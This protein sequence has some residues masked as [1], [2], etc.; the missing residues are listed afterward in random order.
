MSDK[1]SI[2]INIGDRLYPMKI[3]QADE[4]NIRMAAKLINEKITQYR[5][6]FSG[7]DLVDLLSMVTLQYTVK[8]LESNKD[9]TYKNT[10]EQIQDLNEEIENYFKQNS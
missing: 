2:N 8:Y 6:K 3:E 1:L 5:Q 10:I 7:K 9:E 4:E